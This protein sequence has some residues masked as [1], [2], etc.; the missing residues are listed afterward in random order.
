MTATESEPGAR[1]VIG[2]VVPDPRRPVA[3]RVMVHGRPLLTLSRE[4]VEAERVTAGAELPEP[5][6][7]RLCRAADEEAAHRT[8]LR[9]L[10]RRPFA[11]RDLARRL[12]MKGH[13]PEAAEAALPRLARAGV[14]DPP[15]RPPIPR[16]ASLRRA[17]SGAPARDEGPS[18]RGRGGGARP[19]GAGRTHRR[20]A[21]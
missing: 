3:V 1:R 11:A 21:L 13:P 20:P 17:R 10:E 18:P 6:Y 5:V 2:T 8:A 4:V 15:P 19:P 12:V 16:A 14:I 7:A 9:F